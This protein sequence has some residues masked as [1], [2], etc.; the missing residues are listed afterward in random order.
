MSCGNLHPSGK[1]GQQEDLMRCVVTIVFGPEQAL[2]LPV[3]V[4]I[5]ELAT[6]N[7]REWFEDRWVALECEPTRASGKVLLMDKILS[8][9][10]V[11][12]YPLLSQSSDYADELAIHTALV[13]K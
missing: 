9:T 7:A 3:D 12:G 1:P 13:L 11:L 6:M 5:S 2:E 8:V 10:E 4:V